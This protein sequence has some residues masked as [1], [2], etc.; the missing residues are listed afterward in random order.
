V[1]LIRYSSIVALVFVGFALVLVAGT[2]A[3]FHQIGGDAVLD[4]GT[5]GTDLLFGGTG[6]PAVV[7]GR[8]PLMRSGA[9]VIL[10]GASNVRFGFRSAELSTDLGGLPV[11][12]MGISGGSP[13][14]FGEV[15]QLAYEA[16]PEASWKDIT[17]VLGVWYGSFVP[18]DTTEVQA[19]E[20]E[21]SR[22]G[23]YRKTGDA[24]FESRLPRALT[25]ALLAGV[26]PLILI[27]R[28]W[29]KFNLAD[30][31]VVDL[32]F[33]RPVPDAGVD[34]AGQDQA[35]L[36]E[37]EKQA[38]IKLRLGNGTNTV[39]AEGFQELVD[40]A[41]LVSSRGSRLVIVDLPLPA[42]H[43]SAVPYF[44]DYQE[45]K[46][47]VIDRLTHLPG[48]SYIDL[49]DGFPDEG[50]ADSVHP[51]PRETAIWAERLA[52]ALRSDK[53]LMPYLASR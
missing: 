41:Q 43:S 10:I 15:A 12:N 20:S 3:L 9:Q 53:N 32:D 52:A 44:K 23:I 1:G 40:L 39:T 21:M 34:L 28:Q 4:T 11:Q 47:P 14:E 5:A 2:S 51:R 24:A 49:Q 46:L 26:R 19:I 38:D 17:F 36:T 33:S 37:A 7:Y 13:K 27:N 35:Q 50:F 45:R 18:H 16:V 6:L 42:W 8:A 25:P 30:S 31:I 48:I 22:Y 29:I